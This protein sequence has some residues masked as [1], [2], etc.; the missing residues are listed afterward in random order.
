[1]NG[2]RVRTAK[3][4]DASLKDVLNRIYRR[5]R[6]SDLAKTLSDK[7]VHY[8]KTKND[9]YDLSSRQTSMLYR[10]VHDYDEQV[11]LSKKRDLDIDWTAHGAYRS[12]L[13]DISPR[14]VN[15]AVRDKARKSI[16]RGKSIDKTI[17]FRNPDTGTIV[18]DYKL[19]RS[20]A[21]ADV[22]TVWASQGRRMRTASKEL[23]AE[24]LDD[25]GTSEF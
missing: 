2:R 6:D 9:N 1:M 20:P 21:T 8:F 19:K 7:V 10:N 17:R 11:P 12:E 16:Q 4:I 23:K 25:I 22:V 24:L 18:V 5:I 3:Q 14:K 13:R 15:D